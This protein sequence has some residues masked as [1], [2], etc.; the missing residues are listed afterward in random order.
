MLYESSNL[1]PAACLPEPPQTR[2]KTAPADTAPPDTAVRPNGR[3]KHRYGMTLGRLSDH[4][5]T[6]SADAAGLRKALEARL[7]EAGLPVNVER[8]ASINTACWA[9]TR[10]KLCDRRLRS[11]LAGKAEVTEEAIE[12]SEKLAAA[13]ADRDKAI[14]KL[15]LPAGDGGDP[16]AGLLSPQALGGP[17]DA[18]GWPVGPD[19]AATADRPATG[20]PADRRA[21]P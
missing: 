12:L 8:A 18:S 16:F 4:L 1:R 10:A 11:V 20:G 6:I 19:A 9:E 7:A 5:K 17:Q 15:G 21:E 13:T 2:M 14:G 3:P